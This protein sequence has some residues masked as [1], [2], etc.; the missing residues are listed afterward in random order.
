MWEL[1]MAKRGDSLSP[2]PQMQ[3]CKS[4]LELNWNNPLELLIQRRPQ[5]TL[6]PNLTSLF[7]WRLLFSWHGAFGKAAMNGCLKIKTLQFI[8]VR[9]N[10]IR[11]F[12][13]LFTER[14]G[15]TTS[16]SQAGWICGSH[17]ICF[18]QTNPCN[19]SIR[20]YRLTYNSCNQV[21]LYLF[22]I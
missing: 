5:Q 14:V 10:S 17:K 6:K 22:H 7:L 11:S 4:L 2:V 15:N 12:G 18:A 19:F 21:E 13:W 8:I 1:F 3:L 20:S 16:P 9:M